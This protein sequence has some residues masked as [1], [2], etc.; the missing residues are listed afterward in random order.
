M[1]GAGGGSTNDGQHFIG[2]DMEGVK[3]WEAGCTWCFGLAGAAVQ[4]TAANHEVALLQSC[5]TLWI[6]AMAAS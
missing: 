4:R 6:L 2:V 5:Q 3:G 1:D